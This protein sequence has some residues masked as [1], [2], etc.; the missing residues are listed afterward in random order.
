MNA[1]KNQRRRVPIVEA[2][3]IPVIAGFVAKTK[4]EKINTLDEAEANTLSS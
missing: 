1:A 3:T 4:T 2:G